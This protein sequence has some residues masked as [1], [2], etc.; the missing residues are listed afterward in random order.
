MTVENNAEKTQVNRTD[1]ETVKVYIIDMLKGMVANEEG[2]VPDQMVGMF[3]YKKADDNVTDV[4]QTIAGMLVFDDKQLGLGNLIYSPNIGVDGE[5]LA[6]E[7]A[8]LSK[9]LLSQGYEIL[10]VQGHYVDP[11]GIMSHG[12]EARKVM[13]HVETTVMLQQIR[14]M[15][16]EMENAMPKLVLPN[17]GKIILN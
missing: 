11:Q 13:R 12:D 3:E 6:I 4:V 1:I 17:D 16:Q 15:Q 14:Q 5:S 10:V 7:V 9:Y 2:R 8:N